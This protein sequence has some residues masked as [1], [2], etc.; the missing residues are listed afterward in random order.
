MPD[1]ELQLQI[2]PE[3]RYQ[4]IDG[5]GASGCW[6]AQWLGE[7]GPTKRWSR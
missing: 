2:D 7:C 5:F 4:R 3:T 1:Q 6:W